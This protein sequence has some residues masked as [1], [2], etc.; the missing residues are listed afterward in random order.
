MRCPRALGIAALAAAVAGCVVRAPGSHA[1]SP[2][3]RVVS[4]GPARIFPEDRCGPGSLSLV[5]NV[6]GDPVSEA[7]LN[8]ELPKTPQG[9]LSVDLLLAARKRGFEAE[10]GAG[11]GEAIRREIES[12]RCALLMLRLLDAPG[13][14]HDVFHYIAVDGVDPDRGRFRFQFGDGRV[15]WASLREVERGWKGA[16]HALLRVWPAETTIVAAGLETG[17]ALEADGRAAE[18]VALYRRMLAEHPG[19]LRAWVNLGNAEAAQGRR[20]EAEEAY[21]SALKLAPSDVDALNN[22]AWL[23]LQEAVRLDEAEALAEAAARIPGPDQPQAQDTLGRI[24]LARGR[25]EDAARTFRE[26]L[27]AGRS[28]TANLRAS[29]AGGLG[30]AVQACAHAGEEP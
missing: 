27:A 25:C 4:T 28:Q 13:E 10:L 22:L 17:V 19:V 5:L 11:D 15:R 30:Q 24:Q 8:H 18:A 6:L 9:V 7:E 12:G 23:L 21:R 16:G 1:P 14:S 20:R 26:A 29:L 3:A 2:T